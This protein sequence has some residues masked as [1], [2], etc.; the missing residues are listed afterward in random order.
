M[1]RKYFSKGIDSLWCFVYTVDNKSARAQEGVEETMRKAKVE[2]VNPVT[3]V[4]EKHK[5]S[6]SEIAKKTKCSYCALTHAELGYENTMSPQVIAALERYGLPA[7][8][9]VAMYNAWRE[10]QANDPIEGEE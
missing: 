10:A 7:E 5:I 8:Q 2:A 4:R 6:R 1:F 9:S 3:Y